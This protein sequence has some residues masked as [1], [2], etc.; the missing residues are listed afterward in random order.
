[1]AGRKEVRDLILALK[2]EGKTVFLSSHILAEVEQICDR[3]II[4]NQG[5]VIRAGTLEE[6][7]A[8]ASGVEIV[9]DQLPETVE[10]ELLQAAS[11][12]GSPGVKIERE[13][14]GVKITVAPEAK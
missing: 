12:E 9:V 5:R 11:I 13:A 7:L 1:P 3:A 4:I 10:M 8:G 2:A 14:H 6:L